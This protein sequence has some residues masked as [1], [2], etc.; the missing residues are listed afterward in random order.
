MGLKPIFAQQSYFNVPSSDR[1]KK[2]DFFLQQQLNYADQELTSNSTLDWGVS[3]CVEMGMNILQVNYLQGH[4][5]R[6]SDKD[7]SENEM[8]YP[9]ITLNAQYFVPLNEGHQLS[10]GAISGFSFLNE[11]SWNENATLAF[12]NYQFL[13]EKLKLTSGVYTGNN[14]MLAQ[15]T[16]FILPKVDSKIGLQVGCEIP[17]IHEKLSVIADYFSGTHAWGVSTIGFAVEISDHWI[18]SAGGFFPNFKSHNPTGLV[19][20][21]TR[22]L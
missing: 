22:A 14:H 7:I 10:V 8:V 11:F 5:L 4:V 15:G 20:E 17:I 13:S 9:L 3:D 12:I 2:G 21:L 18:I 6:I 1:T 19:F 16:R